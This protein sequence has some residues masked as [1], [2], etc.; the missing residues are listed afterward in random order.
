MKTKRAALYVRVS[1]GEQDTAMQVSELTEYAERRGWEIT[2]FRDHAQSG[3]KE[4]RPALDALLASVKRG[5]VDIILVWALDRLAR[6]LP[7]LL[8]LAEEFRANGVDFCC[9]KQSID[10][11]TPAGAL[12]YGVLGA[13]AQFERD[14][15]RE[16]V[17]SGLAQARRSGKRLGRPPLR[18][19]DK[20]DLQQL[21]R[22]RS[23]GESVR[24]LAIK[25]KTTQYIVSKLISAEFVASKKL[26]IL[27]GQ[28]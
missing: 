19:F 22:L 13:V 20:D 2:V 6:S 7:R 23:K 16:R 11:S 8:S 9:L 10:T 5:K 14:M 25:F 28:K 24:S 17:K 18:H 27:G 3:A 21:S 12:T 15:L 26:N 1:S 4:S